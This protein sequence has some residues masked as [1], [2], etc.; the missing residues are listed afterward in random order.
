MKGLRL[1]EWDRVFVP[2]LSLAESLLRGTLVYFGIL[3]L[4]RVVLKRQN[5]GVGLPDVMLAVLVS[6]CVSSSINANA[7]SV[8][9]GLAA[10]A[11]ML[12]WSYVLD[13]ATFRWGWLRRRLESPPTPIVVDGR[14]LRENLRAE[15]LSDD[16]LHEQLRLNG[17]AD[18]ARV[19]AAFVES[20][21]EVSVIPDDGPGWGAG[22]GP[23]D[24]D[25]ALANFL[26][27]ARELQAAA[28]A[29]R[30]RHVVR[31]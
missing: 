29:A 10:V 21:G 3:V 9:N 24:F 14:V 6:E 23:P 17:V 25:R 19:K 15:L 13:W 2:D 1:P 4:F 5:G 31:V 22:D 30:G 7:N 26:A 11:A 27:A 8:P 20:G 12:F 16:E 28:E 18:P